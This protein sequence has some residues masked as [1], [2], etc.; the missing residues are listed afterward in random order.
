MGH[1]CNDFYEVIYFSE[2]VMRCLIL[3]GVKDFFSLGYLHADNKLVL[4]CVT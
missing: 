3:S 1:R 4:L 2:N